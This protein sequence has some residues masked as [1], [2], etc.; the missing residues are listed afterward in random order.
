MYCMNIFISNTIS[1]LK[2]PLRWAHTRGHVA[3][4]CC[5]NM[6]QQHLHKLY[7]I[8]GHA[9]GMCSGDISE[10]KDYDLHTHTEMYLEHV[11]GKCCRNMPP[12]QQGNKDHNALVK[13]LRW[14]P[15]VMNQLSCDPA[16][17]T[18]QTSWN[19]SQ[20]RMLTSHFKENVIL[21]DKRLKDNGNKAKT[22][23]AMVP[24]LG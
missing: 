18:D 16:D 15:S 20:T 4:R 2:E 5:C 3:R 6:Y 23:K 22:K 11:P 21:R 8:R 13:E 1:W 14:R 12:R 24:L 7:N 9:T 17:D 19:I 10:G